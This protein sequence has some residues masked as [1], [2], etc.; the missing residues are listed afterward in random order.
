MIVVD[1]A[2][3]RAKSATIM[4]SAPF[5]R[6]LSRSEGGKQGRGSPELAQ[7]PDV[8]MDTGET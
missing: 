2:L 3:I 1:S 7:D 6:G 5:R 4:E 8:N